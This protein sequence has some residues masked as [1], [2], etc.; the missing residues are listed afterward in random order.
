MYPKPIPK[1][2]LD[3]DGMMA[4]N[5]DVKVPSQQAVVEYVA[6]HGGATAV[7]IPYTSANPWTPTPAVG[8]AGADIIFYCDSVDHALTFGTPTD[9][10]VNG[11]VLLIILLSDATPG[12]WDIDLTTCAAFQPVGTILPTITVA[13]K[14]TAVASRYHS[15]RG[16]WLVY[17]VSQE[18]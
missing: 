11:Q 8:T 4:A 17:G 18:A 14:I 9:T 6:A 1:N 10:P 5:S 12:G 13:S 2:Y 3:T 7:L 16:K 15:G